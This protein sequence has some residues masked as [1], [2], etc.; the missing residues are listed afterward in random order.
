MK[1][2][3]QTRTYIYLCCITITWNIDRIHKYTIWQHINSTHRYQLNQSQWQITNLNIW[4]DKTSKLKAFSF[5]YLYNSVLKV[6]KFSS[7][8]I[9][10]GSLFHSWTVRKKND[11][12]YFTL[13]LS[14]VHLRDSSQFLFSLGFCR[15]IVWVPPPK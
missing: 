1:L 13:A 3:K 11:D 6:A 5:R 4:S 9:S 12:L 8:L 7:F 10:C 14:K 15:F 2:K